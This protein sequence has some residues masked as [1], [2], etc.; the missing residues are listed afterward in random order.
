MNQKPKF[1]KP[2]ISRTKKKKTQKIGFTSLISAILSLKRGL[3]WFVLSQHAHLTSLITENCC[4]AV[5]MWMR[6][7]VRIPE[8]KRSVLVFIRSDL[9]SSENELMMSPDSG[10]TQ[11]HQK[12]TEQVLTQIH[13]Q[14]CSKNRTSLKAWTQGW[15]GHRRTTLVR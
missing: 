13:P 11:N 12:W 8:M 5:I 7:P 15:T 3:Y 14:S 1:T 10:I 6:F 2:K 9:R 4:I